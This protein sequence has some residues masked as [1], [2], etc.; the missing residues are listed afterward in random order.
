M[1]VLDIDERIEQASEQ[2]DLY[3]RWK[4][5][6]DEFQKKHPDSLIYSWFAEHSKT[7][8]PE[9]TLDVFMDPDNPPALTEIEEAYGRPHV[10][11]GC[12]HPVFFVTFFCLAKYMV[13]IIHPGIPPD[14]SK[15]PTIY[16][17]TTFSKVVQLSIANMTISSQCGTQVKFDIDFPPIIALKDVTEWPDWLIDSR[18]CRCRQPW[19][20]VTFWIDDSCDTK[21]I[22][23]LIYQPGISYGD[24]AGYNFFR[25]SDY[26]LVF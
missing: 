11:L 9:P 21:S 25:Q 20:R 1:S 24:P 7:W 12:G 6:D 10:K 16:A 17:L 19:D 3:L 15:I 18:K 22:D 8:K 13:D 2:A 5:E 26:F 14:K 4:A 23:K